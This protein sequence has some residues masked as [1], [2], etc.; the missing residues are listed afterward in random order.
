MGLW[1]GGC[2]FG[3]ALAAPAPAITAIG[4]SGTNV[5][6]NFTTT[7]GMKY[8][9]DTT[10]GLNPMNWTTITN[11]ISGTGGILQAAD[12]FTK[13]SAQSFYRVVM[14]P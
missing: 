6:V 12:H 4:I 11:G 5:Q 14:Y 7:K 2:V 1:Q 3:T 9:L 10:P 8:R 13:G